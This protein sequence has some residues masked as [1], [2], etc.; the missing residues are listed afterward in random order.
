MQD[1]Q[2]SEQQQGRNQDKRNLVN[3]ARGAG[4]AAVHDKNWDNNGLQ[5]QVNRSAREP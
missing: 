4:G 2:N 5:V 1:K 3:I